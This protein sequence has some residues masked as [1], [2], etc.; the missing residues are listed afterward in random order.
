M[1]I[2]TPDL[3][4]AAATLAAAL[5]CGLL[6]GIERERRKSEGPGR[7]LAGLRTFALTSVTGAATALTQIEGLIVAG[8]VFVAALAVVA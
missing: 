6:I 3:P 2:A 5:G 7:A 4:Q 8:A 1:T